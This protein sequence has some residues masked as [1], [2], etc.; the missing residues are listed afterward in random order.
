MR[1][2]SKQTI[3]WLLLAGMLQS[4][5]SVTALADSTV[6]EAAAVSAHAQ[7]ETPEKPRRLFR[8]PLCRLLT[9]TSRTS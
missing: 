7:G 5:I 1:M 6:P 3:A 2:F 8:P 9:Q 4:S